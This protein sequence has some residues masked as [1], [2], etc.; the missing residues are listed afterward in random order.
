[1]L[2]NVAACLIY[3]KLKTNCRVYVCA[4]MYVCAFYRSC[5]SFAYVRQCNCL[6]HALHRNTGLVSM[7]VNCVPW[8][9]C[10]LG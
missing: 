3:N 10:I 6:Q 8:S 7:S 4:C 5:M 9:L 1:M 2:A